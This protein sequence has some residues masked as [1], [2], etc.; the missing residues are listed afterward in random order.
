MYE[1]QVCARF[2]CKTLGL[3]LCGR[4]TSSQPLTSKQ[5]RFSHKNDNKTELKLCIAVG[6]QIPFQSEKP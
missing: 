5:T 4:Y 6:G 1:S 3:R 2:C